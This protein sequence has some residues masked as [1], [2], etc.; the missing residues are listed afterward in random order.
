MPR[1]SILSAGERTSLLAVPDAEDDLIRHYTFSEPDLSVIRQRRGNHNR[2]G[3]AVQLCY[4]R[5]PGFALPTDAEPPASL[6][7]IVGRQLRIEPDA[8]PQVRAAAGRPG[9]SI[10]ELQAWL[11]LT[12]FRCRR[13]PPLRSP[14]RRTGPADRPGH[15]AGRSADR[16]AAAAAHHPAGTSMSSSG[17]AARR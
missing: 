1:R 13:L 6:L 16:V 4:L 17:Y 14:A 11:N 7:N 8:W 12:P 2:L 15:R 9:A 5:Y 10:W 3:F